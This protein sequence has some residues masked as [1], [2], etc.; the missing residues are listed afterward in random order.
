[1]DPRMECEL[2]EL[3]GRTVKSGHVC[4]ACLADRGHMVI[5]VHQSLPLRDNH[6][7]TVGKL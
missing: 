1:M 5:T 4:A 7:L 2:D 3:V 6:L